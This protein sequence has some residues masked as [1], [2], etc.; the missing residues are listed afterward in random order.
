MT[1]PPFCDHSLSVSKSLFIGYV[2]CCNHFGLQPR[3][4]KKMQVGHLNTFPQTHS[5][6]SAIRSV[7]FVFWAGI[8]P[9]TM[10][11]FY[12]YWFNNQKSAQM[13]QKHKNCFEHLS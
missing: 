9:Q 6:T 5:D 4:C 7:I 2:F 12:K 1:T 11:Y 10:V 3:R 8:I 13:L